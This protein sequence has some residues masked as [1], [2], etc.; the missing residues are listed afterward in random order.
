MEPTSI[1]ANAQNQAESL[2]ITKKLTKQ[3]RKAGKHSNRIHGNNQDVGN[4]LNPDLDA[5]DPDKYY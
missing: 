5:Y 1:V 3:G 4:S 2:W